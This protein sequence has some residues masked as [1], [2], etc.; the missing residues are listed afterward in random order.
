M[1]SQFGRT[2]PV[3]LTNTGSERRTPTKPLRLIP[4]E[5][6]SSFVPYLSILP[7]LRVGENDLTRIA[8]GR[9]RADGDAVELSGRLVD[10]NGRPLAGVLVEIWNA[11]KY[12]RYGHVLDSSM[13]KPDPNFLGLGRTITDEAGNY[14]F[15]TIRPGS[16]L[17]RPDIG[18]WRPAHIHFSIRGGGSRMITQMY[19]AGDPYNLTDQ[20]ALFMGDDFDRNVGK[21]Y[22]TA[23]DDTVH[24]YR[25]DIAIGGR[26]AVFFE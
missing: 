18:R 2:L 10:S 19:F 12:G 26:N 6:R 9:P 15:L 17:A 14:R 5:V 16:Y 13:H 23:A 3:V 1:S 25:F 11:N 4:P 20:Q 21:Q 8:P 24:G 7:P 22:Q